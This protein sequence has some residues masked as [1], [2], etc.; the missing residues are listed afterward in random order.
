M[1]DTDGDKTT[2]NKPIKGGVAIDVKTIWKDNITKIKRYSSRS[3]GVQIKTIGK[4]PNISIINTYT[5]DVS[6]NEES[7]NKHWAETREI[8]KQIHIKNVICWCTNNSG[9]LAQENGI[10]EQIGIWTMG[11]QTEEG[12]G[13]QLAQVCKEH[14]LICSNT[15]LKPP[16]GNKGGLATWLIHNGGERGKLIPPVISRNTE[17][18]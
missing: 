6:Y 10:K 18:G 13:K 12:G 14:D 8:T 15:D 9:Q 5:P 17:I 3:A 16:D 11:N 1:E 7:H 4:T 2:I